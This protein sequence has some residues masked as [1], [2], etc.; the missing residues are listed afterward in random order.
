MGVVLLTY[1]QAIAAIFVSVCAF[2]LL[3]W[4][5]V[6]WP[7]FGTWTMNIFLGLSLLAAALLMMDALAQGIVEWTK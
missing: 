1:W 5:M 6:K 3:I 7:R 2:I 4:A